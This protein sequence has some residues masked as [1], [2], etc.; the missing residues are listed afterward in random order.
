MLVT[1]LIFLAT[2]QV[3]DSMFDVRSFPVIEG[4]GKYPEIKYQDNGI[5]VVNPNRLLEAMRNFRDS[6]ARDLNNRGKVAW[7]N[8]KT[9]ES[10]A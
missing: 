5:G 10:E 8:G 4:G 2:V 9:D 1:L 3:G 7:F 6:G